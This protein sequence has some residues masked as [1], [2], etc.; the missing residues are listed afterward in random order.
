ME[1]TNRHI[2]FLYKT[3]ALILFCLSIGSC[4]EQYVF[5]TNTF[6]S[7]P[8]VQ[9]IITNEL[10]KQEIKITRSY[11]LEEYGP[12]AE[13]GATVYM[14]DSDNNTYEFEYE[15]FS[16]LYV[17]KNPF[18]A[19]PG[20]SYQLNITTNDGK[21]YSSATETL[22]PVNEIQVEPKIETVDGEKGVQIVVT[23]H[24]PTAKSQFYRFEYDETYKIVSP[25]WIPN[26]LK[27]DPSNPTTD[28]TYLIVPRDSGESRVCYTTKKSDDLMLISNVGLSEDKINLPIR[29]IDIKS[30]I[31]YERY[32]IIVREYVQNLTSY[33]Y[34]KTLKSLSTSASLLSQ[35][36]P[37]FNY[38]N[39][40]CNDNPDDKIIGYFEVSSVSS[41]RI[42][43]TFRD[44]FKDDPYPPFIADCRN[45]IELPNCFNEKFCRGPQIYSIVTGSGMEYVFY[46]TPNKGVTYIF[47][48][49]PCGDC[50]K[51][52]SN[53]KPLFWID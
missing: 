23:S 31:L 3:F 2:K 43:F 14:T 5:Q 13:K 34:Y 53:I 19:I 12:T 27:P 41:K 11:R 48:P 35:I 50:T 49:A 21:S 40:K 45:K 37:G 39:L 36:Q 46:A 32:S 18:Q 1:F 24:D 16:D 47:T 7:I 52:S 26:K 38:G 17:S 6:E 29:F 28:Y 44:I 33:T 9:A 20:K 8:V 42:F 22:T 10:K 30:P 4:T 51:I 15:D 25:D